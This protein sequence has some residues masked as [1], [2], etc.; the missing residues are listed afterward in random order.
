LTPNANTPFRSK[1]RQRKARFH[2]GFFSFGS[3][4]GALWTAI[5]YR[6]WATIKYIGYQINSVPHI[7]I[8][9]SVCIADTDRVRR[10]TALENIAD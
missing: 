8:A 2:P 6:W 3:F 10:G 4:D 9:I 7:Y 5:I 1:H